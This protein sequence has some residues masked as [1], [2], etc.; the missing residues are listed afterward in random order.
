MGEREIV[1]GR[2]RFVF[3]SSDITRENVDAIVNAANSHLKHGGGV[4]GAIVRAGGYEIQAE[5]D[6]YV[7]KHGPVPPGGVAVTGAGKLPAKFVIH[8][9]GPIG[10]SPSSDEVL[11]NC[12]LNIFETAK[13]LSIKSIALPLVGTGIFGYPLERFVNVVKEFIKE[14]FTNYVGPLETVIF[15][16]IDPSKIKKLREAL[17]QIIQS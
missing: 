1:F 14:Y 6:E 10:D 2:V 16:D 4:A 12:L 5:S 11:R 9:V 8:T 7:A 13:Q 15:C 3:R 17:E